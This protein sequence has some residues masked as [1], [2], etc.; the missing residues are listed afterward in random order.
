MSDES[1]VVELKPWQAVD[2]E[3]FSG[4]RHVNGEWTHIFLRKSGFEIPVE[5]LGL[6]VELHANGIEFL[7]PKPGAAKAGEGES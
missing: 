3:H 1:N 7:P 4:V 5:Q 6:R 2:F